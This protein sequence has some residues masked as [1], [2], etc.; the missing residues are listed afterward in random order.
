MQNVSNAPLL[1]HISALFCVAT[2]FLPASIVDRL[3]VQELD[4]KRSQLIADILQCNRKKFLVFCIDSP[5]KS[6]M[7]ARCA[8]KNKR[9]KTERM[10][11]SHENRQNMLFVRVLRI[12]SKIPKTV[13]TPSPSRTLLHHGI[14]LFLCYLNWIQCEKKF[15]QKENQK[16]V[17]SCNYIGAYKH[18][19]E[20]NQFAIVRET[21][22]SARRQLNKKRFRMVFSMRFFCSTLISIEFIYIHLLKR[23][24]DIG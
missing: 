9:N 15:E 22:A 18:R 5:R 17:N 8:C 6:Q 7:V 23:A 12:N 21:D 16:I 19:I 3:C 1:N 24:N 13:H 20:N 14:C 2:W 4:E 10:A 11:H